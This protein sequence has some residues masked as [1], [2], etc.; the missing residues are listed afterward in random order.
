MMRINPFARWLTVTVERMFLTLTR[1]RI[2]RLLDTRSGLGTRTA[3]Q[4]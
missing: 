4:N 2:T 3:L 1:R